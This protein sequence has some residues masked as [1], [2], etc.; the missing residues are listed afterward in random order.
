KAKKQVVEL[1][2]S[3][4]FVTHWF[5]PRMH[6]FNAAFP[7]VDVRFQLTSGAL[8]GPLGNVDLG[9]RRTDAE[10]RDERTW[11][12][13]PELVLPVAS[14]TYV[15]RHGRRGETWSEAAHVLIELSGTEIDWRAL[16]AVHGEQVSQPTP[17][18]EFSD[19]AVAL[20]TAIGGQGIALGWVSA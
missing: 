13:A 3:T 8:K 1:S 11:V 10:E 9:M 20:Q 16:L 2:L 7:D 18:L 14:P 17:S 6:E 5:V 4:A 19:Y 15:E 12:F